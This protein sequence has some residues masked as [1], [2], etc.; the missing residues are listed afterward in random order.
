[1]VRSI[2]SL[3]LIALGSGC[4]AVPP[5]GSG[6]D[7]G[8]TTA[9]DA[10]VDCAAIASFADD[11]RTTD[12]WTLV[13]SA[14]S[15]NT[16]GGALTLAA[17]GGRCAVRSR[18]L[19]R[20]DAGTISVD[21]G[22][23]TGI[24]DLTFRYGDAW[25]FGVEYDGDQATAVTCAES[26]EPGSSRSASASALRNYL[27]AGL[28]VGFA[29]TTPNTWLTVGSADLPEAPTCMQVELGIRAGSASFTG[30]YGE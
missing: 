1:V 20:G 28:V 9:T 11:F 23:L 16:V 5:P 10:E 3:A 12:R 6:D 8:G 27:T 18:E 17:S 25:A 26:C 2:V 14:C 21:L 7:D 19:L 30:L 29:Q 4:L 13:G 24:A 22:E 15:I